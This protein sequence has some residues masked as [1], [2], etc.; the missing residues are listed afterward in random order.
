MGS[1][2][3]SELVRE[4]R[5]KRDDSDDLVTRG[6]AYAVCADKIELAL[7]QWEEKLQTIAKLKVST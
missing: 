7:A 4:L 5:T 1:E 2:P 3:L 6:S